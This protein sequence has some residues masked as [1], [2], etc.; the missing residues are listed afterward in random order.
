MTPLEENSTL[1]MCY[2]G[3][4]SE[5]LPSEM[6]KCDGLLIKFP[7]WSEQDFLLT[8][9]PRYTGR[10]GWRGGALTILKGLLDSSDKPLPHNA[11][12]LARGF[13][14][15]TRRFQFY[16]N[17]LLPPPCTPR[18]SHWGGA[19]AFENKGCPRPTKKSF[20]LQYQ[21]VGG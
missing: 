6:R 13:R 17:L 18:D 14:G 12:S 3:A 1:F 7:E 20:L 15:V 19:E 9:E 16:D 5:F 11:F 8:Q 21:R 4:A 10:G 2:N